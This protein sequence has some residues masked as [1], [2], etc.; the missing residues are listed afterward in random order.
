MFSKQNSLVIY[1]FYNTLL[2]F[3]LL[4]ECCG[5]FVADFCTWPKVYKKKATIFF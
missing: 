1:M 5:A 2:Y 3:V 4:T